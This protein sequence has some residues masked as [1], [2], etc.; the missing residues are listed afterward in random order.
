MS[1][2]SIQFERTDSLWIDIVQKNTPVIQHMLLEG[3]TLYQL[4]QK[5]QVSV[6]DILK[7][8]SFA[9][10]SDIPDSTLVNIPVKSILE[11]FDPYHEDDQKGSRMYYKVKPKE[12]VF[13]VARR[14]FNLSILALKE[15]NGLQSDRL[16]IGQ[17]LY[18]GKIP[19]DF[20]SGVNE[21]KVET[22]T[23][24][25]D[26][27][28]VDITEVRTSPFDVYRLQGQKISAGKG[29]AFWDRSKESDKHLFV[30]HKSAR[31]NSILEL[32]NPMNGRTV[33]AKVVGNIPAKS[34]TSDIELV[35]SPA[36]AKSLGVLDARFYITFQ[37]IQ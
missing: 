19:V 21:L 35:V 30:L 16:A 23:L 11:N 27:L 36:V 37:Y 31:P 4:K 14:Y 15:R 7:V 1:G 2:Q 10:L 8:N 32:V 33:C 28:L 6:K 22:G 20:P 3:E 24:F 18:I 34:Y 13:R 26:S 9:D 29:V 17:V 12:T 5:Y 25:T